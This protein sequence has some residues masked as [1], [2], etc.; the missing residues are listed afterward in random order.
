[1]PQ[2]IETVVSE[3]G[4][5]SLA[6]EAARDAGPGA[7]A[8]AHGPH[9]GR[10]HGPRDVETGTILA[11]VPQELSRHHGHLRDAE[12]RSVEDYDQIV[13][14][15]EGEILPPACLLSS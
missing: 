12:D 5:S 15:M 1:M 10:L 3:R 2:G 7:G 6:G 8:R 4:T 13:L 14:L 11:N 9:P